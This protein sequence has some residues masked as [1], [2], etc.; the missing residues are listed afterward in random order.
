MSQMQMRCGEIERRTPRSGRGGI[1]AGRV[2]SPRGLA[3]VL[4][5]MTVSTGGALLWDRQGIR[6]LVSR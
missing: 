2:G 6:S 4:N 3:A 1:F 5:P